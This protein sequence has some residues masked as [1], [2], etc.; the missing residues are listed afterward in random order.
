MGRDSSRST[1][2][3]RSVA[4]D[5]SAGERA[6]KPAGPRLNVLLLA[7]TRRG[8]ANTV[9][10][11]IR[12]LQRASRHRVSVFN[13]CGLAGSRWLRLNSYDVVVIHY[14]LVVT[15]DYYLGP[16]FREE[17]RRFSGVKAQFIQDEYRWVDEIGATM[18]DMKIDVIFTAASEATAR[19]LYGGRVPRA[20]TVST[21]TG[22]LPTKLS[23]R[24]VRP[25]GDRPID[26]GYR[27]RSVPFWLGEF[28]QDK[29]RIAQGFR[30]RAAAHDLRVDI[31]WEE[32]KRI[33]GRAWNRFVESCRCV[34]G[35]E[36]G[37][38]IGDWDGSLHREVERYL[39]SNPDASFEDVSHALLAPHEGNLE[40]RTISPRAFEAIA[41][42]TALIQFPGAYSGILEPWKHYIPLEKDFSNFDEVLAKIR[43]VDFLE[44]MT[45]RAYDDIAVPQRYS[46]TALARVFDAV[47]DRHHGARQGAALPLAR[48][49]ERASRRHVDEKVRRVVWLVAAR[50]SVVFNRVRVKVSPRF[51]VRRLLIRLGLW[52]RMRRLIDMALV[53]LATRRQPGL[54]TVVSAIVRSREVR[55]HLRGTGT[56]NDLIRVMALADAAA[57]PTSAGFAVRLEVTD[58]GAIRVTSVAL[59]P[60]G[61]RAD[62]TASSGVTWP[63][64]PIEEWRI[65]W[66]HVAVGEAFSYAF[67]GS[68]RLLR[69]VGV[70]GSTAFRFNALAA[71]ARTHPEAV[72][73]VARD[74]ARGGERV[75]VPVAIDG[76]VEAGRSLRDYG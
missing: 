74:M 39:E 33:Y 36:S 67:I 17:I 65:T 64:A 54:R 24:R 47:I 15:M 70:D 44:A 12:A 35:T 43:D 23:A 52:W 75:E 69:P 71:L 41:L 63:S 45:R 73:A 66:S 42:R 19:V 8:H 53:V 34:L 57:D 55:R 26:V 61:R 50:A 37:A 21:L 22:Y 2:R 14:S 11:H 32:E 27:G 20:E 38:S 30:A 51:V 62:A 1:S 4:S 76:Q 6:A 48:R 3:G 25:L 29:V 40:L 68:R 5:E 10:D 58:A 7:D 9:V 60:A 18:D 46:Y 56:M 49:V 59:G 31:E 13:P 72:E 28:G 16:W